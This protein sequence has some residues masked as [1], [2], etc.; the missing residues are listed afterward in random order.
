MLFDDTKFDLKVNMNGKEYLEYK[1]W[2]TKP[3]SKELK[4][5]LPYFVL[6]AVGVLL[7]I[8]L[9]Q[10]LTYK[11]PITKPDKIEVQETLQDI[12]KISWNDIAKAFVISQAHIVVILCVFIGIAW[13]I[14]GF[15]FIIIK[16]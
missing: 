4:K 10:D 9:V 14:H 1:K 5:A 8:F 3:I 7:I 16:R 2:K 12:S 6:S 11:P 13:I 15:G